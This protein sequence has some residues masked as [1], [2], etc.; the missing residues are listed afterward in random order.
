MLLHYFVKH[1]CYQNKPLPINY[2]VVATYLRCGGVVSNQIKKGLLLCVI[3]FKIGQNIRQSYKHERGCLVHFACLANTLLKDEENA[4]DTI[5]FFLL[6]SAKYSPIK[7]IRK[8][9]SAINLS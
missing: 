7:K 3:F 4:R 6:E 5:T 8:K 2:K 1:F 9:D